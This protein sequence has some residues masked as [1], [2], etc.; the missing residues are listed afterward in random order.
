MQVIL[1]Y[2]KLF[3]KSGTPRSAWESGSLKVMHN[4]PLQGLP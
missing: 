1:Y 4:G 2:R 3:W